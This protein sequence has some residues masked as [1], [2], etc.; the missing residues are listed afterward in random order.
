MV[1]DFW[2]QNG[3]AAI[4]LALSALC[5]RLPRNALFAAGLTMVVSAAGIGL[6]AVFC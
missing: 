5:C 2:P 1:E 3:L 6:S 4:G